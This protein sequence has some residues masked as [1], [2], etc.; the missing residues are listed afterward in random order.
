MRIEGGKSYHNTIDI[1]FIKKAD[2]SIQEEKFFNVNKQ[3]SLDKDK[4]IVKLIKEKEALINTQN[5]QRQS[6]RMQTKA[7]R[8]KLEVML[9]C[10]E[11]SR[12]ITAGDSVPKAD[13]QYLMKH[14]SGLYARSISMRFP[15]NNP[16]EYDQISKEDKKQGELQID[17]SKGSESIKEL[18]NSA[19][20]DIKI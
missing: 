19:E 11:I 17:V 2:I 3:Q 10:L 18:I 13:H 12:R 20:I 7:E 14:D 9:T 5:Q 15:K 16:Y 6:S 8:E 1:Q 4:D